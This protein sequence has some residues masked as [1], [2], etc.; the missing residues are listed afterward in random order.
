VE[1]IKMNTNLLRA[2]AFALG[3]SIASGNAMAAD[4]MTVYCPMSEDD[5]ASV[6]KAFEADTGY[7]SAFVRLGAGEI[8]ARIRAEQN[9]P[10]AALWLAGAA[11][12]FIQGGREGLLAAHE[13]ANIGRVAASHRDPAN[14]W[15]PIAISPIVFAYNEDYLAELGA[16][17]PTSWEDYADPVFDDAV[18]LAHPAAS[19]TAYVSLATMVQIF[20]E[21]RA[22][23]IVKG[24]DAN[25]V[26]YTR[27]GSAPSRMTASGEVALSMAFSQD[28]EALIE[29]GFPISVSFP[30]EGTG[31]EINA[32]GLVANAPEGQREAATAF[33]DWILSDEGQTAIGATHRGSA[34]EGFVN[35][36]FNID[37]SAI[38]LIDYDPVW[39]GENRS[40]L[41][42]RYESDVR[43]VG[44]AQ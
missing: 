44:E 43:N 12:I 9:N 16:E 35:P 28:I 21:D 15:T 6:L 29:Q 19:G 13:S 41:L 5:C 1:E 38:K 10:Q 33:L 30:E 20:G 27:S 14:L 7:T 24:I 22:F 3:A 11:D 39:A 31:F 4:Q 8:L 40:R 36:D 18:A 37:L 25:V 26:Q 42:E 23:D 32:A 34:V 2:G 17:P